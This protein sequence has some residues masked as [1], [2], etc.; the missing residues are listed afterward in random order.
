MA[1]MLPVLSVERPVLVARL[2]ELK[3][4]GT[5]VSAHVLAGA[6]VAGVNVRTVWR[7]L[8]A[9][10]TE[11]RLER[12][13]RRGFEISEEQ[14]QVLGG[15]G[16][17]VAA[18]H[19]HLKAAAGPGT[20]VPSRATLYRVVHRDL[21][22]GRVLPEREAEVRARA[23]MEQ[24]L[25][26]LA[27]A[28]RDQDTAASARGPAATGPAAVA[29]ARLVPPAGDRRPGRVGAVAGVVLPAGA[30]VVRTAMVAAV[31]EA[32]G[33]AVAGAGQGVACVYGD[34]GRGKTVALRAAV[35]GLPTGFEAAWVTAPVRPSVVEL[36]RAVFGA[37]GVPGRFPS[38][39]FQA[40]A[41]I[42]E[43]LSQPWVL[44]VEEAQRL[45]LPCLEYLQGLYD[46]PGTRVTLVL[47]GAGV[48]RT[49]ARL[50]QLVGL[51]GADHARAER[52]AHRA[53]RAGGP[54]TAAPVV[55]AGRP[56]AVTC[57]Q[58]DRQRW[59]PQVGLDTGSAR[60]VSAAA[61]WVIEEEGIRWERRGTTTPGAIPR[62]QD[63][64]KALLR[65]RRLRWRRCAVLRYVGCW[66]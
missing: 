3:A 43:M 14:W 59:V 47:C 2:L 24:A 65:C 8:E 39:S 15:A 38:R 32:L 52:P 22:A 48:E 16:G 13:P 36:R 26:D 27:L 56:T 10:Q 57:A 19:R 21:E 1:Q 6:Q 9:A 5:L 46:H 50:P 66:S 62:V 42:A 54:G 51:V 17:S 28:D 11:G 45:P 63:R 4:A 20:V 49:V 64:A 55:P 40:D 12:R 61:L 37:L 60:C 41:Q 7:W 35:A 31:G 34:T 33:L 30:A 44:V 23:R 18:L 53:G 25:T 58:P 29:A